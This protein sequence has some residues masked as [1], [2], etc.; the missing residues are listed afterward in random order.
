MS[1]AHSVKPRVGRSTPRSSR[2]QAAQQSGRGPG[3]AALASQLPPPHAEKPGVL[4][5]ARSQGSAR[6]AV[7]ADPT[8]R[9][10]G[11]AGRTGIEADDAM[12]FE[13]QDDQ[14]RTFT[15]SEKL[16]AWITATREA[17]SVISPRSGSE[18]PVVPVT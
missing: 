2:G 11:L 13:F 12:V 18:N 7:A 5:A 9:A 3:N 6:A 17:S 8:S 15:A 10:K 1:K 14:Q 16:G 4:D